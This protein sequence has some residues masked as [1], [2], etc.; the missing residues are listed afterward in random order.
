MQKTY[1]VW[2]NNSILAPKAKAEASQ[3]V[4]S[5]FSDVGNNQIPTK[6]SFAL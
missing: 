5:T 3:Y 1:P 6:I 4:V 2:R